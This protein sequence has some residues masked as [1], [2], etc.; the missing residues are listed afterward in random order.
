MTG[1]AGN[2]AAAPVRLDVLLTP[3]EFRQAMDNVVLN[4]VP[5]EPSTLALLAM[6]AVGVLAWAWRRRKR[7]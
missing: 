5:A 2:H 4:R 3:G 1:S 7:R 6:G